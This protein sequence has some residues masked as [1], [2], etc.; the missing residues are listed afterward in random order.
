MLCLLRNIAHTAV[1]QKP[2]VLNA[3]ARFTWMSCR[4]AAAHS[5]IPPSAPNATPARFRSPVASVASLSTSY[6]L[7]HAASLVFLLQIPTKFFHSSV[8]ASQ[9]SVTF[10]IEP[11][12]SDVS[13]IGIRDRNRYCFRSPTTTLSR[14]AKNE[15]NSIRGRP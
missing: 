12:L 15:G 1:A 4:M 5:A 6:S 2:T 11:G 9:T 8:M 10:G 3:T 13:L 14:Q 7:Q